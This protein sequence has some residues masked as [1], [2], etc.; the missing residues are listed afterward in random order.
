[1][2]FLNARPIEYLVTQKFIVDRQTAKECYLNVD[3]LEVTVSSIA[4]VFILHRN[5]G[6]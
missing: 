6:T 4:K 5:I 2:P 3:N 1:M